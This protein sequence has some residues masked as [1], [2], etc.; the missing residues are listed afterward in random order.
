MKK[1]IIKQYE[2][3]Y[4]DEWNAFISKAKNASFLFHRNFMEYHSDRFQDYSLLIFE[5]E[6]LIAVLP[7]NR[8]G[9]T[10]YSHQ[11]LT[12]GGLVYEEQ[13]KLASVIAIFSA[14]LLFL[15]Q[16]GIEKMH[17]K[18]VPSIYHTKPSEEIQYALFLADAK[19]ARRDTLSVIDLLQENT[20]AKGRKSSLKKAT[21]NDLVIK[22]ESDFEQFWN[23]ILIPNL[24]ERH[25]AK[26][27]H[28]L[29]E[30]THLNELFPGNIIQ[31]N[32]YHN[33]VIVAGATVFE[34]TTVTHC[35]YISKFETNQTLSSLDFLFNF[36]VHKRFAKKRFFDFGSSNENQGKKLNEG[37]TYW[38]ESFGASTIVHDFYEVET[39]NY[40]KLDQAAI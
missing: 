22:E 4:F 27:V 14:I 40:Y 2:S 32:V 12:Y 35:Q 3:K 7:A 9:T 31:F 10:V 16:N 20:V 18:T 21:Q 25:N 33:D 36:L 26:P 8:V 39:A 11:G 15:D 34:S 17:I 23:K 24:S 29:E 30:I 13:T 6:K 38:K 5:E 19:L 37:L 1:H 28:T